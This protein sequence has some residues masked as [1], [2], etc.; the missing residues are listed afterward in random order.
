MA[1]NSPRLRYRLDGS[2]AVIEIDNPPVNAT[3]IEVR[4]GL[5]Q[6][7]KE[8]AADPVVEGLVLMGSHG[9]FIAGADINE[10]SSGVS[11]KFP[12]L[13]DLQSQMEAVPKPIV[14]AIQGVA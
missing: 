5:A 9:T 12:T 13:R 10:I 6:A 11:N 1:P 4:E 8:A 14:A 3:S 2:V 7:L